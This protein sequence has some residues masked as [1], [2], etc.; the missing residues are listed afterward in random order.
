MPILPYLYEDD[1]CYDEEDDYEEED[2]Y[3]MMSR[4]ALTAA[5]RNPSMLRR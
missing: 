3:D 4:E 2:D 5:E 1:Y